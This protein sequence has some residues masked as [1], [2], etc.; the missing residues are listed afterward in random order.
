MGQDEDRVFAR[1]RNLLDPAQIDDLERKRNKNLQHKLEIE[2]QIAEKK[3]IKMLEDEIQNLNNLKIE[4]EA[5]E[6]SETNKQNQETKMHQPQYQN[7]E[8]ALNSSRANANNNNN[9][10]LQT[11][12]NNNTKGDSMASVLQ[13]EVNKYDQDSKSART[14]VTETR[15][16]EIYRKMQEAELSAAEEKHKRLL[17]RLQR[18]GHDTSQLERKF[19]E[20]KAK[21]TGQ[22]L[23]SVVNQTNNTNIN[24]NPI[25]NIPGLNLNNIDQNRASNM[26]QMSMVSEQEQKLERQKQLLEK[27]CLETK[28]TMPITIMPIQK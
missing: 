25:S 22:P 8:K 27:S 3:R 4:N 7:F 26:S 2:A 19:A 20:L 11:N 28:K 18:G 17:K 5:K 13:G 16:Q 24:N 6:Q 21:L 23:P 1:T 14:A 15:S 12:R 9:N 10:N